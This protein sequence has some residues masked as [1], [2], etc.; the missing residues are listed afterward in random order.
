MNGE[1][2][3]LF[4]GLSHV[5]FT[6]V[7]R[8]FAAVDCLESAVPANQ[9]PYSV[10]IANHIALKDVTVIISVLTAHPVPV[11]RKTAIFARL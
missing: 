10:V 9:M 5:F 3:Q 6:Y 4:N 7:R 2:T 11:K 8:E 1:F